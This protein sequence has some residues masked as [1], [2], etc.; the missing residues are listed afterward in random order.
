MLRRVIFLFCI[1]HIVAI[2]HCSIKKVGNENPKGVEDVGIVRF[3]VQKENFPNAPLFE[4][5]DAWFQRQL[6]AF[7]NEPHLPIA[8]GAGPWRFLRPYAIEIH[9]ALRAPTRIRPLESSQEVQDR[10]IE[11]TVNAQLI[12]LYPHTAQDVRSATAQR[13]M[14]YSQA[15]VKDFE[16][17]LETHLRDA[18]MEVMSTLFMEMGLQEASPTQVLAALASTNMTHRRAALETVRRRRLAAAFSSLVKILQTDESFTMRMSA[19]ETLVEL[20]D[21]A[22]VEPLAEFATLLPPEQTVT[23]CSWIATFRTPDARRFLHWTAFGHSH[24]DVRK[25][26]SKL[27]RDILKEVPLHKANEKQQP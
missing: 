15:S 18:F 7:S 14:T 10:A 12:P 5:P 24:P 25:A 21:P 4:L 11:I 6:Q 3:S 2:Y 27:L 8:L 26:A 16:R 9:W 1:V 17:R 20:G 19:A 23:V 13:W 22:A